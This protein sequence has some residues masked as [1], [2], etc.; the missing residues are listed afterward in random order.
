MTDQLHTVLHPI[1]SMAGELAALGRLLAAD[2]PLDLPA[3]R[4]TV[5]A[6]ALRAVPAAAH[7]SLTFWSAGKRAPVTLA[8]TDGTALASDQLQYRAEEGP[9]LQAIRDR[10]L[11]Q[12][13]DLAAERR[14]PAYVP[15][16]LAESPVRGVLSCSLADGG[17][18]NLALT[19][20]SAA[21]GQLAAVDPDVIGTVIG[22]CAM[23][24]AAAEQRHRADNLEHALESSR[25]IGVAV[26]V[27]MANRRVSEQDALEALK[28]TSQRTNRKLRELAEDVV[29]LGD[30]PEGRL[31]WHRN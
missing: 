2:E 5:L 29:L 21:A 31:P 1:G 26:G 14:W 30:L 12:A 4:V 10:G 9:S 3:T 15:A 24:L 8:S 13:P 28:A 18:R 11:V 6:G 20:Y 23:A 25:R 27:L 17:H 7:A 22:G 16:A 19:F